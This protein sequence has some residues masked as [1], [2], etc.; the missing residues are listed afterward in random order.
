M[1]N[2]ALLAANAVTTNMILKNKK[3]KR[4]D[5]IRRQFI[6]DSILRELLL[7]IVVLIFIISVSWWFI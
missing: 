7:F 4:S 3:N 1:S 6:F 2:A 5:Y